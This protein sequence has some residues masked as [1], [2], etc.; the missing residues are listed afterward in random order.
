MTS[1]Q[2]IELEE[3]LIDLNERMTQL[4]SLCADPNTTDEERQLI[5]TALP[6]TEALFTSL[7]NGLIEESQIDELMIQ[8]RA[9][10]YCIPEDKREEFIGSFSNNPDA[11]ALVEHIY[12]S[13][14]TQE[15]SV[16]K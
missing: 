3:K 12:A 14:A 5:Q 6:P 1:E 11:K 15:S 2:M 7:T 4:R 16:S 9:F 13:Q 10:C 8:M